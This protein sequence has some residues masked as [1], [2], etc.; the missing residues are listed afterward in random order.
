MRTI[1][2]TTALPYAN[3][4]L[5]FGHLLEHTQSDIWVRAMRLA[6]NKI[7]HVCGSDAHGTPIMLQAEKRGMTPAEM[8][9]KI[10]D[11]HVAD[12]QAFNIAHDHYHTTH[13]EENRVLA[14]E[15]YEKIKAR[16][17]IVRKTIKQAYDPEKGMFLPDRFVKGT[18][19][20]CDAKDQYGDSCEVCGTTYT[21]AELKDAYS[22]L[23]GAAPEWRES[24]HLFFRLEN[25]H[26]FLSEWLEQ[27]H[28][29]SAVRNK[30][31]EWLESGL[32]DWNIS[33]DGPYFGFEIPGEKNK[34][35]Y[36]WLDA[37][38][39]Y[40][41]SFKVLADKLG[42][43]FDDFWSEK[44]K[45]EL[46]HFIGKDIMYFHSLFWPAMLKS[47]G[48]RTPDNVFTH[49]FLTLEG[50]KMSK[51]RG[52]FITA[53]KYLEFGRADCLRYYFAAKLSDGVDDMDFSFD[54]FTNRINSELVGKWANIASRCGKLLG[55]FDG[56][57]SATVYDQKQFDRFVEKTTE[58]QQ[59]FEARQYSRAIRELMA[60][61][62][63]ANQFIDAT[64]PWA[65]I[66]AHGA[67]D[68]VHQVLSH[69]INLFRLISGMLL[70]IM[71]EIAGAAFTFLNEEIKHFDDLRKPLTSHQLNEYT[72]LVTR[73]DKK[74]LEKMV[75]PAKT[76]EVK[77]EETNYCTIADFDKVDLRVARILKAAPVEGADKLLQLTVD[78]GELGEKNIF[79]GVKASYPDPSVLEGK[80]TVIIANLAPRKMRFGL[81]EGM[82]TVA[83]AGDGSRVWLVEP[84]EGALPGMKIQ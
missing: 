31:R 53:K 39:G 57:L 83:V 76:E 33:R 40:A 2:V 69:G 15:I 14:S 18:C 23:T 74:E 1:L 81:S 42:L 17:D 49:G 22:A 26:K 80:L 35:F 78:V 9:G 4:D 60:L 38:I 19:P 70:P 13:S 82:M 75:E 29:Q 25:Y 64:K 21:P 58:I 20:K 79:A 77:K 54:D 7:Y 6:G 67:T 37:P 36:V 43:N 11:S 5:H 72:A 50:A 34:Y 16:G 32:A 52:T 73:I 45:Y 8:V 41:S 30:M 3:G 47:A 66:K 68:E 48:M 56:K 59:A 61:A 46:V 51:S 10:H 62:D 55:K 44:A 12:F 63:E 24:E 27:E 65:M 28:L 84:S 71:P